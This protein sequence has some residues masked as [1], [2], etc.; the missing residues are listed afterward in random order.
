MMTKQR[1]ANRNRSDSF[2]SKPA[3]KL[4]GNDVQYRMKQL[5]SD[6]AN[7]NSTV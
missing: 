1:I 4:T 7:H 2:L 3:A 5:T 6:T